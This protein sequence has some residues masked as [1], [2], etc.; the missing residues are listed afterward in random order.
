MAMRLADQV[1]LEDRRETLSGL[2]R[3]RFGELPPEA[4]Q[5]LAAADS[6]QID[7]WFRRLV[8]AT[9]WEEVLGD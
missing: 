1:R 3:L 7:G 5:R 6:T 2:L 4:R 8:A 9:R